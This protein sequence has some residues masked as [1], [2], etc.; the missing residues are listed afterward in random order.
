MKKYILMLIILSS[1]VSNKVAD[2]E[3]INR[4]TL[5][6]T[7]YFCSNKKYSVENKPLNGKY[8][9]KY[10]R[11]TF[12]AKFYNGYIIEDSY[13]Y[14]KGSVFINDKCDSNGNLISCTHYQNKREKKTQYYNS[15]SYLRYDSVKTNISKGM[16]YKSIFYINGKANYVNYKITS[17]KINVETTIENFKLSPDDINL[18]SISR[19]FFLKCPQNQFLFDTKNND[20]YNIVSIIVKSE[21]DEK[22]YNYKLHRRDN[23]DDLYEEDL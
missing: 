4:N 3:L 11:S 6:I 22:L 19:L 12:Y 18:N 15:P 7:P 14:R 8:K 23:G 17:G 1:C 10:D 13:W 2:Y 20:Y 9:I 21:I 16:P 5:D